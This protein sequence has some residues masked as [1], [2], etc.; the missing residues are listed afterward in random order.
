MGIREGCPHGCPHGCPNGCPNDAPALK[1]LPLSKRRDLMTEPPTPHKHNRHS[2]RLPDYDYSGE[3]EYFVTMCTH[4]R[5]KHF[6]RI[7]NGKMQLSPY[8]HIAFD[9]W[10]KIP[11]RFG[12]VELDEFVVMPDHIHGILIFQGIAKTLTGDEIKLPPKL[13]DVVGA[14]KSLVANECL[15]IAKVQNIVLGKFWQRNYYEHIICNEKDYENF[16][17]Y[18]HDNPENWGLEKY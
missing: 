14:Y 7:V 13:G 12:S 9:E 3:G 6:G 2:I 11:V 16:A 15:K 5:I 17:N 1:G 4:K 8:G 18:I 10:Q